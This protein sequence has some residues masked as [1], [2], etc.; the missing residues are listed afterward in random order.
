MLSWLFKI[1]IGELSGFCR[2]DYEVAAVTLV[3]DE[4]IKIGNR[5]YYLCKKC[6]FIKKKDLR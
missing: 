4:D 1:I 3:N 6:K 2:H 5:I